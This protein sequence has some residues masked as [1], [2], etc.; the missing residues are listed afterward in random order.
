MEDDSI[1][2]RIARAR[3]RAGLTQTQL[4]TALETHATSVSKWERDESEPKITS[5]EAVATALDVSFE[6]LALGVGAEPKPLRHA[7]AKSA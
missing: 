6:W 1:G 5:L 3:E 2:K 4:A 7:S